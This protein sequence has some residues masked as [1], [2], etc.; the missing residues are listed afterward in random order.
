MRKTRDLASNI[1]IN[2]IE[3]DAESSLAKIN[4]LLSNI[5]QISFYLPDLLSK[6]NK[7]SESIQKETNQ[8]QWVETNL[9]ELE[10]NNLNFINNLKAVSS[11]QVLFGS[12]NTLNLII[13]ELD[14]EQ[15]TLFSF[16]TKK[17]G[18]NLNESDLSIKLLEKQINDLQN[19]IDLNTVKDKTAKILAKQ[20]SFKS[21][22]KESG[23]TLERTKNVIIKNLFVV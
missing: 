15:M 18:V 7:T 1:N 6:Y 19:T 8:T 17:S 22:V 13:F 5:D 4:N 11:R 2:R 23:V 9:S 14:L 12:K 3:S 21:K 10:K 16:K 20:E